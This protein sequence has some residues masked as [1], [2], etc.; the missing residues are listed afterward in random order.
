METSNGTPQGNAAL[1]GAEFVWKYYDG[2]FTKDNLPSAP[3]RTWTTKTK[4]EKGG[5]GTIHYIT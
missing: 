4:A 2:Y 1:E 5:D 3:T